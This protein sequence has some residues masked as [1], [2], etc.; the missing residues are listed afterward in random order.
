MKRLLIV[1][2][3]YFACSQTYGQSITLLK[4]INLFNLTDEQ[5]ASDLLSSKVFT[6]Q[7]GEEVNGFVV[8]HYQTNAHPDKMET[9]LVG[10]GF[11]AIG[12]AVL[13]T[14]S[15]VSNN[16]QNTINLMGQA[17][18]YGFSL[19]FQGVDHDD[20]IYIYDNFLYHMV[21]HISI[22]NT[23]SA[24]DISQKQMFF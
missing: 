8:K 12:G 4:L 14:I 5:V 18:A 21:V 20:N 24:I 16:T 7:Y 3:L 6:L 19:T 17:R 13:H 11:K 2:C 9:V 23:K 15:Y 1:I 10:T 22:N